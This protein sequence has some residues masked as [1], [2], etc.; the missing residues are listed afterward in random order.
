MEKVMLAKVATV[1]F[2]GLLACAAQARL[3]EP[4]AQC[5]RRYGEPLE[6]RK[7]PN[8]GYEY[9]YERGEY[10]IVVRFVRSNKTAFQPIEAGYIS[11]ARKDGSSFD[12]KT[13]ETLLENNLPDQILYTRMSRDMFWEEVKRPKQDHIDREWVRLYRDHEFESGRRVE[14]TEYAEARANLSDDNVL[15]IS[16]HFPLPNGYKTRAE[17]KEAEE[18]RQSDTG[19]AEKF[20]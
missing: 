14:K 8:G 13:I 15:T 12:S 19:N 11:Y 6:T 7:L 10:E 9:C 3:G 18:E 2:A 16:S 5:A 20:F 4:P 17:R 1:F